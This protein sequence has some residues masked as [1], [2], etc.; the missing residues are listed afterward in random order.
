[1]PSDSGM[2]QVSSR[3]LPTRLLSRLSIRSTN[4]TKHNSDIH[5]AESFSWTNVF[6]Y[7]TVCYPIAWCVSLWNFVA[8]R[9]RIHMQML[10]QVCSRINSEIKNKISWS[11]VAVTHAIHGYTSR[12]L[13]MDTILLAYKHTRL[14]W[15]LSLQGAW[16]NSSLLACRI[17]EDLP[18]ILASCR[19]DPDVW[20][21]CYSG[22]TH[23]IF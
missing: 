12:R 13:H 11:S 19:K 6:Q 5:P 20:W 1:M 17:H 8:W 14:D 15:L 23:G 22:K 7:D 16:C 21:W 10:A 4:I 3:S 18:S 2:A 9:L